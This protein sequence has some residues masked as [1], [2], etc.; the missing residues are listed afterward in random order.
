LEIA[1]TGFNHSAR[2]KAIAGEMGNG[3]SVQVVKDGETVFSRWPNIDVRPAR[4]VGLQERFPG[5]NCVG[6]EIRQ[7]G[8]HPPFVQ[9][10][11]VIGW[12]VKG[13]EHPFHGILC[14]IHHGL[15]FGGLAKYR[16]LVLDVFLLECT[17]LWRFTQGSNN[18]KCGG[19]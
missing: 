1:E 6:G 8:K 9:D 10:A 7:A 13:F 15:L 14:S 19:V 11:E 18:P 17:F 16:E 3:I 12:S 5:K 2:L 4:I